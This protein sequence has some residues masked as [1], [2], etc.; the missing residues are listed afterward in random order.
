[1]IHFT[2]EKVGVAREMNHALLEKVQYLLSNASLD[3]SF[4]AKAIVYA[5]YLLNRLPTTVIEGRLHWRV[6]QVELLVTWFA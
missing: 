6:G 3:K 4:W 2:N 1:M 5:S